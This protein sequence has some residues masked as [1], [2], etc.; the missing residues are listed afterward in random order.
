MNVKACATGSNHR[1]SKFLALLGLTLVLL[2][3]LIVNSASQTVASGPAGQASLQGD[4]FAADVTTLVFQWGVNPD[5][6]YTRTSDT[7]IS[8]YEEDTAWGNL[9]TM[10]IHPNVDGRERGLIKF[11]I[12]EIPSDATVIEAKL[13]LYAWYW[14]Q[15]F[16]LDIKAYRV[17]KHWAGDEATWHRATAGEFW[18]TAGCNNTTF[19]YDPT[20]FA[21]ATIQPIREF[22]DWDVTQMAQQWVSDPASN[23]GVLLVAE[24]LS[25]EYQFRTSEV[26]SG[27]L[28]PYLV[29]TYRPVPPTI[30][31]TRTTSPT[32]TA[33][34]TPTRTRTPTPGPTATNTSTPT[35]TP[36]RTPVPTV[37]PRPTPVL[38]VFQQG[39]YPSVN[40]YGT[41]DTS[42]SLYRPDAPEGGEDSLRVIGRGTGTERVL[43]RFDLADQIPAGAHIH[44]AKLALYAWSRRTLFGIRISAYGTI[45]YWDEGTATWNNASAYERWAVPG[46]DEVG[47]DRQGTLFASRFV[48]FTNRFYDWDV[49]SL[50]QQWV[51]D[52]WSNSGVLL[53]GQNVEQEILF[54]SSDWRVLTQRPMLTVVYSVP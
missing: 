16:P 52:P 38:R 39:L 49:T 9:G 33:T 10:R 48:Y 32:P 15:A 31:P 47:T 1:S 17:M 27:S 20:S 19:D 50:V 18:H 40:Y 54:R 14:S 44:S 23:E 3:S 11:D 22:Y 26:T 42:I 46:C 51:N 36:T 24:G 13:N 25:T 7:Y 6:Y 21:I 30:T 41:D 43:V 28:R 45:R 8:L 34:H 5:I 29:V 4:A 35:I 37:T 2:F 12:S 53:V